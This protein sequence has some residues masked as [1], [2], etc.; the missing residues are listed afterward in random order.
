LELNTALQTFL[1]ALK[2]AVASGCQTGAGGNI[3]S[4][5]LDISTAKAPH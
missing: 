4:V 1:T 5:T 3:A 2:A